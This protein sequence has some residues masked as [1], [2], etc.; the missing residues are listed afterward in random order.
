VPIHAY[1]PEPLP[2]VSS[3]FF[4]DFAGIRVL[5]VQWLSVRITWSGFPLGLLLV[6]A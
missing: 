4:S 6:L 1:R 2:A 5:P 3:T